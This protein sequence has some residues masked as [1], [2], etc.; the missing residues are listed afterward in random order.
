MR[1]Y[2]Q[3]K[4]LI[5][6]ISTFSSAICLQNKNSTGLVMGNGNLLEKIK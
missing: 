3:E 1:E 6:F 2:L 5:V 4:L